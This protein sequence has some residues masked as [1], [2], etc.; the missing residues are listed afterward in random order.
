MERRV[1]IT[2]MG[3]VTPIGNNVESFW[4]GIRSGK[5][6][7]NEIDTFDITE[8]K[9]KLAALVKDFKP[10]DFIDRKEARRMDRFCQ[11]ALAAATEAMED[12]GLDLNSIDRYRAGVIVSSGI[13][14]LKT[15]EEQVEK[16]NDKGPS[17]VSPFF[18]PMAIINM[19]AGNIAI[20]YGLKGTSAS[21]V[22]ACA[23]STHA[24]GEGFRSIKH[25][26]SDIIVAGG[27]EASITPVGLAGFAS[28]NA[29][30]RTTDTKRASIPFDKERSGFVM[31]EGSGII[32]LEELQHALKRGA[33]IYG[34]I[35]GYGS[36]CDGFHITSPDPEGDAAAKAIELALKEGNVEKENISYINAHGTSTEMNDKIETLSI[37][38]VFKDKAYEIPVSSTKSMTG[39]LLGAAGAIES[40]VCIKA[41]NDNFV[42]PTIGYK[43][44]D[45]NCDLDYVPNK[46]REVEVN[47]AMSNSLGFGGHNGVVLF[48]KWTGGK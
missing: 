19:A 32:V 17:R 38:K 14:G 10:E 18:I 6:G 28:L 39:H 2:G 34:E 48:K 22:T 11:L 27:S 40:I 16:L 3:A 46:G 23:S 43:E 42:P 35:I 30:S 44:K 26:Y 13:G 41:I 36:T 21:I 45:E 15:I 29:L 9:V 7:I 47:Y 20:K 4:N 24:I 1:V 33:K 31:G 5:C 37:K 25:G 12:S 8:Q